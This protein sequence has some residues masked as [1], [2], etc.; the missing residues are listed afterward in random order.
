MSER[1]EV[2]VMACALVLLLVL[3][4]FLIGIMGGIDSAGANA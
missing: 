2:S 3:V 4:G 1:G